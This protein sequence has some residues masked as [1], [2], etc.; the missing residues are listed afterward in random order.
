ML[1]W[2]I[3]SKCYVNGKPVKN[4]ICKSFAQAVANRLAT[5][6]GDIGAIKYID[7]RDALHN[8]IKQMEFW[9]FTAVEDTDAKKF[10]LTYLFKDDSSDS[11]T[12]TYAY[13]K[14]DKG[15]LVASADFEQLPTKEADQVLLIKW[16]LE[17]EY[18]ESSETL[19]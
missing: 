17:I 9:R 3:G 4:S 5:C 18:E 10:I 7:L 8:Q 6:T 16:V 2:N 1:M 14:T 15:V 13:L 12:V 19:P 11:Y